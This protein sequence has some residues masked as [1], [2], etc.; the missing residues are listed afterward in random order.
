[1]WIRGLL[2]SL[3]VLGCIAVPMNAAAP[4][5]PSPQRGFAETVRPFL[6]TYCTSCHGGAKPAALLDLRQYTSADMVVQDFSRWNRVLARLAA[7]EMPPRSMKQPPDQA[8]QQVIDWINAT[9]AVEA[10]AHDGDPGVVLARRLSNA[11]YD[12]TIRDL[13]GVDLRPARE[14]PVDP[15]NQAGFDNSGESLAMSP[16]LASKYLLAARSV[17]DHMFLNARGLAFA[18]LPMLVETDRDRYC[19]Q[20][21]VD[22]YARQNTDYA[23]YFR[24]AWIYKHTAALG[25]PNATLA[26]V[27]AGAQ[28]S[29]KYLTIIWR[30][31]E[32]TEDVGPLA[33]L[34]A[35]WRALPVPNTDQF[36][37]ARDGVNRMREF[38]LRMRKDTSLTF[39]SPRVKGLSI[40]TQ[41]LMNWKNRAY[42]TH[43]RDFDRAALRVEGEPPPVKP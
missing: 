1:M 2:T 37:L 36:D 29:A 7:R 43:R 21:I 22:F 30:A 6:E 24:A 40:R 4:P 19:I 9:W 33:R 41:P 35:M 38:V 34:Q 8:R 25:R 31:L 11:E 17:A 32:T 27:A 3:L 10:R 26:D 5:D 14:F 20:Q 18:P 39:A 42:A 15:A 16:A 23:D 28:V 12:Y 13:T